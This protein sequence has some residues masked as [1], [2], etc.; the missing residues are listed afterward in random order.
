MMYQ[1]YYIT[2]LFL[3]IKVAPQFPAIYAT[4][5]NA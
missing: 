4:N 5:F 1:D 2:R 3:V